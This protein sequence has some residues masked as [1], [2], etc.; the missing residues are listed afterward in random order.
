MGMRIKALELGQTLVQDERATGPK[1]SLIG[2]F[3]KQP[4][5]AVLAAA[6]ATWPGAWESV[7][8]DRTDSDNLAL[9]L[10]A[11]AQKAKGEFLLFLPFGAG[12]QAPNFAALASEWQEDIAI[13]GAAPSLRTPHGEALPNGFALIE[14]RMTRQPILRTPVPDDG[15]TDICSAVQIDCFLVRKPCFWGVGGFDPEAP[16]S[17]L[18][19]ALFLALR[20]QNWRLCVR[21]EAAFS[22]SAS[23]PALRRG[24]NDVLAL[25]KLVDSW[26]GQFIPDG[27]RDEAGTVRPHPSMYGFGH[28]ALNP[29]HAESSQKEVNHS[30]SISV[31]ILT[32]NSMRTIGP[33][34]ESALRHLGLDDE[35]ILVDNASR[36]GTADVLRGIAQA[37]PRIRVI[38][39]PANL[40][41]SGGTN[42][43]LKAATGG[44][45]VLLNPDTVVT[46]GW[47]ARLRQH[48]DQPD[49]GAVGPLSDYVAGMQK[50]ELHLPLGTAGQHSYDSVAEQVARA[51]ARRAIET[52]LLIGFCM[53]L[54]KSVLEGMGWLDEELF[55]GVDDL[56]VSWRL[57]NAGLRLLVATDVFIHHEGQVSFK[58]EPSEHV[59]T[60]T[61]QSVDALARKLIRHYGPGNVPTPFELWGID[62]FAPSFDAWSE[63]SAQ[64][65][66]RAA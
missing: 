44:Y 28:V 4:S 7:E 22:V 50:L 63:E 56:D 47:L 65:A 60:L 59:Q 35:I 37:D 33:C 19:L 21:R 29:T 12:E 23:S 51:N 17:L 38:L 8:A 2:S 24:S 41:F 40:G 46:E 14:D 30:D 13:A 48:F 15:S 64:L 42:V 39:N 58:S 62:W 1:V 26:R 34:V 54:R 52:Q 55:L 53:M 11:A 31:V 5:R 16:E 18:W 49:V 27:L 45:V 43:G 36:D 6:E 9:A 61:Q 20:S 57:R 10:N 3:G 25:R 66:L 32:Y